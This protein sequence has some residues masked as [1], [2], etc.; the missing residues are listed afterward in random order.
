MSHF[1]K[2][3]SMLA[4]L[5]L[6]VLGICGCKSS[7]SDDDDVTVISVGQSVMPGIGQGPASWK[8]TEEPV[9]LP[10]QNGTMSGGTE[11]VCVDN[12]HVYV[13]GSMINDNPQLPKML[14]TIWIDGKETALPD[15]DVAGVDSLATSVTATGGKIY[16]GGGVGSPGGIA[17]PAEWTYDEEKGWQVLSLPVPNLHAGGLVNDMAVNGNDIYY[18]GFYGKIIELPDG[19][20][21]GLG[22]PCYWK[23]GVRVD[24]S[25]PERSGVVT[26]S[27]GLCFG[28]TVYENDVY[29]SGYIDYVYDDELF[30]KPCYW[31]NGEFYALI[32]I[33]SE[34]SAWIGRRMAVIDGVTKIPGVIWQ[35]VVSKPVLW[36]GTE[37]MLLPLLNE[38]LIG[39][40]NGIYV[41][42]NNVYIAGSVTDYSDYEADPTVLTTYPCYW[43]DSTRYDLPCP[44]VDENTL[45]AYCDAIYVTD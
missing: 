10:T 32:D 18:T 6:L 16:V 27:Q 14:A 4:L 5:S 44:I 42:N 31:K 21:Y 23:N 20:Q 36:S 17:L 43:K 24:L 38:E 33:E 12:G 35:G 9:L 28:I 30:R 34:D 29:V 13:V 25:Y 7:S 3:L 1:P 41:H 19:S 37:A 11:A 40:A 2:F 8:N 45:E 15:F 26:Y 39:S 22:L